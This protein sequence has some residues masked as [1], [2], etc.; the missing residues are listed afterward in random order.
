MDSRTV[1]PPGLR[2]GRGGHRARVHLAAAAGDRSRDAE[3][4]T[5]SLLV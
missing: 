3:Q 5:L 1:L 2:A 4:E